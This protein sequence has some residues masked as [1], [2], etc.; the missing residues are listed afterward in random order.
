MVDVLRIPR[1]RTRIFLTDG[2]EGDFRAGGRKAMRLGATA[3]TR[4]V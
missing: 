4:M 1:G 3:A 2:D